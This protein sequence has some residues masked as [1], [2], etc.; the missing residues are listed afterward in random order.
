MSNS[1]GFVTEW[2][3]GTAIVG[4][5]SIEAVNLLLGGYLTF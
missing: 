5:G 2:N 1:W 3:Y 4:S